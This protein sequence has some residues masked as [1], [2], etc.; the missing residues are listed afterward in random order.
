VRD[1]LR[2]CQRDDG[3][4]LGDVLADVQLGLREL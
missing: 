1:E 3:L 2:E 4:R